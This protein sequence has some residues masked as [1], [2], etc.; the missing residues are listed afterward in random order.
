M[1][2]SEIHS[3]PGLSAVTVRCAKTAEPIELSFGLWTL[4]GRRTHK[5]N[6]IS[7]VMPVCPHG[8]AH[9]R[10]LANTIEPFVC[11]GDAVLCEISLTT[12]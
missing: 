2:Y 3:T 9:W 10:H 8:R 1:Q 6:H 5:F 11:G 7:Q 12:C 4:V